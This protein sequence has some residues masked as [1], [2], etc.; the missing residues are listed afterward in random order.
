MIKKKAS[1][2]TL[3]LSMLSS[4]ETGDGILIC[5]YRNAELEE[6][7]EASV[8]SLDLDSP[9]CHCITPSNQENPQLAERLSTT[10]RTGL[11]FGREPTKS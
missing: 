3:A 10:K 8:P 6:F 2:R 9:S 11:K 4:K 1:G 5:P 7:D